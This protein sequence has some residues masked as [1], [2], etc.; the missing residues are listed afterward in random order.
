ATAH[1]EPGLASGH[2]LPVRKGQACVAR[3]MEMYPPDPE[4][5]RP[6]MGEGLHGHSGQAEEPLRRPPGRRRSST[7][8][9][10]DSGLRQMTARFRLRVEK[11]EGSEK[12]ATKF[13]RGPSP[14]SCRVG[15]R[16]ARTGGSGP[17]AVRGK[18]DGA[19]RASRKDAR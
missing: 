16:L 9:N 4:R 7:P 12:G 6:C 8:G 18:A 15:E 10:V 2:L 17:R 5:N 3:G 11:G 14:G 1:S 19:G 13:S